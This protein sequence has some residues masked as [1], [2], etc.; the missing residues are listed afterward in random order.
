MHGL[1]RNEKGAVMIAIA[2]FLMLMLCFVAFGTEAGRWYLL[3]A[4]ISKTVDAAA[5]AGA[6]NISNPYVDPRTLA[7][8]F[9]AENFPTG[10]FGTPGSGAPGTATFNVELQDDNRIAVDGHATSPAILAQLLGIRE[11]PVS[12]AGAAQM[13]P[14]EIMMIL[15]RSGSMAGQ[16]IADLKV[17]AKSFLDFFSESQT[18][19]K[20]GLITFARSSLVDHTLGTNFVTPMKAKID[21]IVANG[22]TNPE[23]AI[24]KA[25]GPGGLTDQSGIPRSA[26]IKQFV[27]FFS[28]GRPNAFRGLF[29]YRGNLIDAVV[30]GNG[31]CDFG[32]SAPNDQLWRHDR[33]QSIAIDPRRTGDGLLAGSRCGNIF[34]V[35]WMVFDPYP[36]PGYGPTT[37]N[38]PSDDLGAYICA[39]A[40]DF[41][42]Q[43]ARELKDDDIT[44]YAVGLGELI[45][46]DFL[47]DLASSPDQV[48]IAPTSGDL[49]SLFQKI[50]QDIKLRLVM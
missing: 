3:R 45:N 7:Q 37:C 26:R 10:A 38:I 21:A 23:D 9:C 19:D 28:D 34:S 33:E 11:V 6:K 36:V 48:Y 41:A 4:E 2:L 8:E 40:R 18:R 5:L 43:H 24:D 44:V 31:N 13:R 50:A 16:P 15:D 17:A 25:D 29:R 14:V 47:E 35:R 12:S 20:I 49:Q 27:V 39:M 30:C 42:V 22:N 1:V 46:R 32:T